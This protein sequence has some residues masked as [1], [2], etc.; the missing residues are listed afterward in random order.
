MPGEAPGSLPAAPF[1]YPAPPPTFGASILRSGVALATGVLA[2]GVLAT[3]VLAFVLLAIAMFGGSRRG[4]PSQF[5]LAIAYWSRRSG[6]LTHSCA[7]PGSIITRGPADDKIHGQ[8]PI[9]NPFPGILSLS[10]SLH[11][12]L[13]ISSAMGR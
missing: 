12:I 6:R 2:T 1:A 4:G 10:S 9:S 11:E 5:P 7:T 8:T 3:G 13:Y